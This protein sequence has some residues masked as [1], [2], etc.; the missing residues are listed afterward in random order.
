M[1]RSRHRHESLESTILAVFD[2]IDLDE[3][4]IATVYF[5]DEISEESANE[6]IDRL[7]NAITGLEFEA[8][9]GGQPLYPYLISVE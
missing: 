1:I 2:A 9:Y 5:G 3:F 6:M 7:S 4:E 8:V